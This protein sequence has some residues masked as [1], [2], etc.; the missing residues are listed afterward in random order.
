MQ[1]SIHGVRDRMQ[2]IE[3]E[4]QTMKQPTAAVEPERH[5]RWLTNLQKLMKEFR[6][7]LG[8]LQNQ[9][10]KNHPGITDDT[11]ETPIA[12]ARNIHPHPG[13]APTTPKKRPGPGT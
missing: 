12:R 2:R 6:E 4:I 1:E 10:E 11:Q 9:I 8:Q 5:T 3:A 13:P 7:D